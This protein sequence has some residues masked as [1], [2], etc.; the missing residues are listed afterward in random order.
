MTEC[1]AEMDA[2]KHKRN[3]IEI[4]TTLLT[5]QELYL[6][7]LFIQT[8]VLLWVILKHEK[9]K[10]IWISWT[11]ISIHKSQTVNIQIHAQNWYKT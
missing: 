5:N 1:W 4:K 8:E 9:K 11:Y 3:V 7:I 2:A 10:L 6:I